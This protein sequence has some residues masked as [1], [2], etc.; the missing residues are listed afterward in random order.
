MFDFFL[1]A[2]QHFIIF[3]L[4]A[5]K[6]FIARPVACMLSVGKPW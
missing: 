2:L 3:V 6:K 4:F 1:Q 5:V